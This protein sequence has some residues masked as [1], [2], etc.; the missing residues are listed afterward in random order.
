MTF[1]VPERLYHDATKTRL[2]RH[3]DPEA[4][5]LAFPAGT[6]LPDEEAKRLGVIAFY[7]AEEKARSAPVENKMAARPADKGGVK[8]LT[9]ERE[10]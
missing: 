8:L 10:A 7:A 4:A 6:E 9:K 1:K 2:L 5:F 3:N